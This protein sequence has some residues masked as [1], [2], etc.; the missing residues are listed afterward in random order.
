ML[1]PHERELMLYILLYLTM[2]ILSYAGEEALNMSY[3]KINFMKDYILQG[4]R[5]QLF[6]ETTQHIYIYINNI[7]ISR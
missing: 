3:L 6:A 2:Y 5:I 4:S 7:Q 1:N